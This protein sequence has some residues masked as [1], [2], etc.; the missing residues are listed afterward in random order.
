MTLAEAHDQIQE[1]FSASRSCPAFPPPGSRIAIYGAGNYGRELRHLL[2]NGGWKIAAF[3]DAKAAGETLIENIPCASLGSSLAKSLAK[4]GVPIILAIFNFSTDCGAIALQLKDAGFDR[5]ISVPE[6]HESFGEALP[7]RF[8]ME[9]KSWFQGHRKEILEC[10]ELWE[11]DQSRALY[12]ELLA[13]RLTYDLQLLRNP[14]RKGQY[15][16]ADLPA[17]KEPVRFIDGGAYVGDTLPALFEHQVEALAAFEPDPVNF[18]RLSL[19][20]GG[21]NAI[22]SQT[23]LFPC[24]LDET[25]TIKRFSSGQ[26]AASAVSDTGESMIQVAALD[27]VL[28]AFAPNYIKLDIEGAELRA[29]RGARQTILIHRPAIA[30]CLYHLPEHLWEVPFLLR[31]LAP[32]HRLYLRIHGFNGFDSVAYALP[33]PR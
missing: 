24:G 5:V 27:D 3:I 12:V 15:F 22:P 11:D 9:R 26:S 14:D 21:L 6:L 20:V 4:E 33:S 19:A 1:L 7:F 23:S 16:P 2:T 18:K 8:W 25:T 13:F 31:D 29:L 28:P 32:G 30:A 17:F 10:L